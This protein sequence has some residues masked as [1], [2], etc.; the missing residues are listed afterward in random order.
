VETVSEHTEYYPEAVRPYVRE[1]FAVEDEALRSISPA[2]QAAGLPSISVGPEEGRFLQLI[3]TAIG[4]RRALEIGTLAGYSGVWI[5]RGLAQDGMLV[6]IEADTRHAE[7]ARES[8]ARAGLAAR[9]DVRVGK[10]L[11]VLP[12]LQ[13]EAPF[14]LVFIDAEKDEYPD[15]LDWVMRLTRPGSAIVAHNVFR[16]GQVAQPSDDPQ[17]EGIR[18]FNRRLADD[19]RLES[20]LIPLRDGMSLSIVREEARP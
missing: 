3:G 5:A 10:A 1:L 19:S 14:D 7:V 18:E 13:S 20:T 15:Y 9:S 12:T 16:Q 6:T 4:A 2:A 11:D 17:V 8:F